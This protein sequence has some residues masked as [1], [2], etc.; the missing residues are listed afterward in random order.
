MQIE[1]L[2]KP[3]ENQSVIALKVKQERTKNNIGNMQG[4]PVQ[5]ELAPQG[6]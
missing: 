5:G 1:I 3:V 4:S 6:D 2:T